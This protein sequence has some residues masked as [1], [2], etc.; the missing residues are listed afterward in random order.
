MQNPVILGANFA[1]QEL[2]TCHAAVETQKVELHKEIEA[3]TLLAVT[4]RVGPIWDRFVEQVKAAKYPHGLFLFNLPGQHGHHV[5]SS[6][7]KEKLKGS[8]PDSKRV[9]SPCVEYPN[10]CSMLHPLLLGADAYT[11]KR[12]IEAG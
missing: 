7:K 1:S 3:T 4:P 11:S 10:P 12:L 9:A 2:Q 8:P 6:I 5:I